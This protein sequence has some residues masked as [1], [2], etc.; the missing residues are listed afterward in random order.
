M[1]LLEVARTSIG[2]DTGPACTNMKS[3]VMRASGRSHRVGQSSAK[4]Q[5]C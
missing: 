3:P 4:I 2:F 5:L 1:R